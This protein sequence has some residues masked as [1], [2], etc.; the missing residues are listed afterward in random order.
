MVLQRSRLLS[1]GEG[2]IITGPSLYALQCARE[3]K[4][5]NDVFGDKIFSSFR[6]TRKSNGVKDVSISGLAMT[7]KICDFTPLCRACTLR[8]GKS[9]REKIRRRTFIYIRIRRTSARAHTLREYTP[10]VIRISC[11]VSDRRARQ[12]LLQSVKSVLDDDAWWRARSQGIVCTRWYYQLGAAIENLY[13]NIVQQSKTKKIQIDIYPYSQLSYC[14]L[15][16]TI[17]I[18]VNVIKC[19]H[20]TQLWFYFLLQCCHVVEK[21]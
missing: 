20:Y 15:I 3:R 17:I 21:Q 7:N 5:N 9:R 16:F 18:F 14:R 13:R 1:H 19:P 11:T 4:R 12:E 8:D 6:A 2:K 10:Y